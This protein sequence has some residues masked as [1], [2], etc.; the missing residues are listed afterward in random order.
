MGNCKRRPLMDR[1]AAGDA[2]EEELWAA[3]LAAIP[4]LAPAAGSGCGGGAA[5][6]GP[7]PGLA[8]AAQGGA[9]P[10]ALGG[11]APAGA[12]AGA[13]PG[14]GSGSVQGAS[15]SPDVDCD[16]WP[17][18]V[19]HS[20]RWRELQ[21]A[22]ATVLQLCLAEALQALGAAG[23][24]PAPPTR[25]AASDQR[26]H[27]PGRPAGVMGGPRARLAARP[28]RATAWPGCATTAGARD[29]NSCL[30]PRMAGT[31]CALSLTSLASS[32]G[33]ARRTGR[34]AWLAAQLLQAGLDGMRG[35]AGA[36]R[37]VP[38]AERLPGLAALAA[39]AELQPA[40]RAP[41]ASPPRGQTPAPCWAAG[42]PA[43]ALQR[44]VGA[45]GAA[46]GAAAQGVPAAAASP[47]LWPRAR[48]EPEPRAPPTA[49]GAPAWRIRTKNA[50]GVCVPAAA[51]CSRHAGPPQSARGRS[52]SSGSQAAVVPA[53]P[54]TSG[55][56]TDTD[57]DPSSDLSPASTSP[58]AAASPERRGCAVPGLR[59]AAG[60]PPC[61]AQGHSQTSSPA[62]VPR[63]ASLAALPLSALSLVPAP[64][65]LLRSS[66]SGSTHGL[67]PVW[68][69][70]AALA[71]SQSAQGA[72]QRTAPD[73]APHPNQMRRAASA[74]ASLPSSVPGRGTAGAPCSAIGENPSA[75][76]SG[77]EPVAPWGRV[78]G[79]GGT[80]AAGGWRAARLASAA[81]P[82]SAPHLA[83]APSL[84]SAPM[85]ALSGG[86]SGPRLAAAAG[87][88]APPAAACEPGSAAR[89]CSTAHA[90][91]QAPAPPQA[92]AP[93]QALGP[94][95]LGTH[96]TAQDA[97]LPAP[98]WA[99]PPGPELTVEELAEQAAELE[100][101]EVWLPV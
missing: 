65:A 78:A 28:R 14:S 10:G 59:S 79:S 40:P 100:G 67:G 15:G 72:W 30:S 17:A 47:G 80:G 97:A 101:V 56:G 8:Q 86:L 66:S 91:L 4:P 12:A 99:W 98:R 92:R 57:S 38:A 24:A 43:A 13:E 16:D 41:R 95:P 29:L 50:H 70:H 23:C 94:G 90:A 37:C 83:S 34:A 33:R 85:W 36:A 26:P 82:A 44:G 48:A 49:G 45:S 69:Q 93:D 7:G 9:T 1:M 51:A 21:E 68:G 35:E 75:A 89:G 96:G 84:A 71:P 25:P 52:C 76:S 42:P 60:A 54:S 5:A 3:C 62:G 6:V 53:S 63:A 55:P 20:A 77:A 46:G 87:A 88:A 81:G 39:L 2:A 32:G 61:P 19:A 22:A 73:Q 74:H 11:W 27:R 18:H 58:S 64:A 31:C